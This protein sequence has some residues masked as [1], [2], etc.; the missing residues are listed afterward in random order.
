M[1][2]CYDVLGLSPSSTTAEIK[3]AYIKL[4]KQLHPDAKPGDKTQHKKFVE[5]N[6]AY[7]TLINS[8]T[9]KAYDRNCRS[10]APGEDFSSQWHHEAYHNPEMYHNPFRSN[11]WREETYWHYG[12]SRGNSRDGPTSSYDSN[13]RKPK[14]WIVAGCFALMMIGTVLYYSAYSFAINYTHTRIDAKSQKISAA[15]LKVK[16]AA[17]KNGKEKQLKKYYQLWGLETNG[18]DEK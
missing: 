2:T 4:C 5:L 14:S 17:Q 8:E 13:Q 12:H 15:Y 6:N 10:R 16:E 11:Q 7:S 3:E 1:R 18:S 9:R